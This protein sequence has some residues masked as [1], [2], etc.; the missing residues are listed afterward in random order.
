MEFKT[1]NQLS[2]AFQEALSDIYP[3]EE[4][5]NFVFFIMEYLLGY[6]KVDM[7]MKG[8]EELSAGTL[9]FCQDALGKL[10]Q[11]VPIQYILGETEFYGLRFKVSNSVLI[12]RPETEELVHWIIEEANAEPLSVLDIGTG[13]GC[14]PI[15]LKK[16]ILG[17]QVEGWDISDEAL[18]M[19]KENAELNQVKVAFYKQDALNIP[20]IDQQ[21][22]V[23]VSNPPYVLNKE[24]VLMKQNVLDNE[25]HLALFVPDAEPLLFYKSISAFAIK[26]LKPGGKL[27]FEINEAYGKET[28][29]MMEHLGFKNVE[30]RKDLFDKYRMVRGVKLR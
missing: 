27:Y 6:S 22:D 1:I 26:N 23:I 12:P 21:F 25:P 9:G 17:A 2:A 28:V 14:I 18:L 16:N 19:A 10:R 4:I 13:T 3:A 20:E 24:K 15:T 7:L 5:R 11:H 29:E 30:L 8:E